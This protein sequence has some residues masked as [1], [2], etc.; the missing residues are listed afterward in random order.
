[1]TKS[2]ITSIRI[3]KCEREWARPPPKSNQL[4]AHA[5]NIFFHLGHLPAKLQVKFFFFSYKAHIF[6][7]MQKKKECS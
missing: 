5:E 1:M 6:N 3:S 7:S 2:V 4:S